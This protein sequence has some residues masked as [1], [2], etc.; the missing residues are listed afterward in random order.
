MGLKEYP[1]PF[2]ALSLLVIW[3]LPFP[4]RDSLIEARH[5]E[6]RKQGLN[7]LTAVG[8]PEMVLS[9]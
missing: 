3:R 5:R 8:Y 9:C 1:L 6:A 4:L 2:E 7:P